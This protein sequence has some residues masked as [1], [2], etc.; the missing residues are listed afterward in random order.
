LTSTTPFTTYG[1]VAGDSADVLFQV[2][3]GVGRFVGSVTGVELADA[4]VP[5]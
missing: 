3:V 4:V 5:G 2:A 1:F